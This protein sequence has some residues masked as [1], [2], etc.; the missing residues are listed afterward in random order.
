MTARESHVD[1][2]SEWAY[3]TECETEENYD[4][5]VL[6]VVGIE[7]PLRIL[8]GMGAHISVLKQGLIPDNIP[9]RTDKQY[10]IAGITMGSIKTLGSVN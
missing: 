3:A 5:T 7:Q 8:V 6:I 4:G 10:E 9:I 2:N 1:S